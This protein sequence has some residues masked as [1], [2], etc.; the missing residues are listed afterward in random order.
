MEVGVDYNQTFIM[1]D[2]DGLN[3]SYTDDIYTDDGG[4]FTLLNETHYLYDPCCGRTCCNLD[5][6]GGLAQEVIETDAIYY[7]LKVFLPIVTVCGIMGI[8]L[9][10][11]ILSRK[12]MCTSTNCYLIALSAA[13]LGFLVIL[14]TRFFERQFTGLHKYS[15]VIYYEY[16]IIFQV[17]FIMASVWMTVFLAL[18]R[19]IAI[20]HPYRASAFCTVRRARIGIVIV[21]LLSFLLRVPFFFENKIITS[22]T[23]DCV[24]IRHLQKTDLYED[25]VYKDITRWAINCVLCAIIPFCV[26]AFLNI[27]LICEIRK[28]TMYIQNSLGLDRNLQNVLSKE[29]RK[30]TIMLIS[31]IIIFFICE[32]PY[33]CVNVYMSLYP[34]LSLELHLVWTV[35]IILCTCKSIFNFVM[36][37]WFSEKFWD[38]LKRKIVLK[39]L[40]C[41]DKSDRSLVS[42][43]HQNGS[44]S[45][46]CAS[47]VRA[48]TTNKSSLPEDTVWYEYIC[49]Y[50]ICNN[51]Y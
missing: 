44:H 22:F 21:F 11:I 27:R 14:S 40:C 15:F 41:K 45:V 17:A 6:T 4:C 9:T 37:C 51:Y 2:P 25:K 3:M 26:L 35:A 24:E 30:I 29:Q 28:S 48:Q 33:V 47:V 42:S 36:Y 1:D 13:D 49:I 20:V 38:T 43:R 39:I 7:L 8:L 46:P 23:S 16:A 19:Y 50:E 12:S 18:E 31:I 5:G 34:A 32:A 10:I